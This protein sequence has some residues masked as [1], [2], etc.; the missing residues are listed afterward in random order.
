[1]QPPQTTLVYYYNEAIIQMGFISFFAV[2]FPF[3]PIFSFFTNLLSLKLKL[4]LMSRYGKRNQSVGSSGIGN[5]MSVMSVISLIAVPINLCVLLYVRNPGDA[6]IGA[7]QNLDEIK[8]EQR[9]QVTQYLMQRR[10]GFW[11]RTN[12]LTLF[13]VV[14][15]VLIG[16]QFAIRWFVPELHK[17]VVRAEA[18]R[19]TMSKKAL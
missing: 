2:A 14:E 7:L 9:S 15:H 19:K 11:T 8:L 6:E 18:T 3:A 10:D 13:V 16:L 5:W 12:I 1:M 17:N 4:K